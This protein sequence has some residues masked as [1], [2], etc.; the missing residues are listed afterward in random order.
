[1]SFQTRLD[2]ISQ[3]FAAAPDEIKTPIGAAKAKFCESFDRAGAIQIGQKLPHFRL[4]DAVGHEGGW[5][6][7]CSIALHEFQSKLDEL[8]AKGVTLVAISPELPDNSLSTVEKNQLGYTVLSDLGNQYAR[9][10][11]LVFSQP[12]SLR[13]IFEKLGYDLTARNGDDSFEVP[14]PATLLIGHDGIV[15]K[16]FINPD[17]TKRLPVSKAL[18]WIEGL[19]E[20]NN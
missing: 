17:Y 10:L 15:C 1:M 14:I 13:P 20:T 16:T 8:R 6:P 12:K 4:P 2:A 18:E 19:G 9:R 7:Y 3:Q 5:C 11:G